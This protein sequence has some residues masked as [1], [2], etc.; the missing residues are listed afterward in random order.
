MDC[1]SLVELGYAISVLCV[2]EKLLFLF[3]VVFA[4][5]EVCGVVVY[6]FHATF[7]VTTG[8]RAVA[9]SQNPGDN[10][11]RPSR[12]F[13]TEGELL[14]RKRRLVMLVGNPFFFFIHLDIVLQNVSYQ[15]SGLQ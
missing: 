7:L 8:E 12:G 14:F 2:E 11:E 4:C 9:V 5:R 3:R 1:A 15:M 13:K 6:K 10:N